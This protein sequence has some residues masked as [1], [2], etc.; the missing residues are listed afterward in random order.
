MHK[1]IIKAIIL[2][3]LITI[4]IS[5][6]CPAQ[7]VIMKGR[8]HANWYFFD[9]KEKIEEFD[10]IWRSGDFKA[11]TKFINDGGGRMVKR[12]TKIFVSDFQRSG[13]KELDAWMWLSLPFI[14]F[15]FEGDHRFYW[16]HRWVVEVKE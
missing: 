12:D 9:T 6:P 11:Q 7:S 5:L 14:K 3:A 8:F 1:T 13:D 2:A 16:T 4:Y 15:R 10:E